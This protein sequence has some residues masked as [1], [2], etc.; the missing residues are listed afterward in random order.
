M[1][2]KGRS[3]LCCSNSVPQRGCET[4]ADGLRFSGLPKPSECPR[5]G[6]PPGVKHA[7]EAGRC[8]DDAETARPYDPKWGGS[9]RAIARPVTTTGS[10]C[11]RSGGNWGSFGTLVPVLH[12][13]SP[14]ACVAL[15]TPC[16]R[17]HHAALGAVRHR[18]DHDRPLASGGGAPVSPDPSPANGQIAWHR[19]CGGQR[20]CAPE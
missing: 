17:Y 1:S 10:Q 9:A 6:D 15:T 11:V 16:N 20:R 18:N 2:T 4:V 13:V 8:G 5:L 12:G 19:E 7:P 3:P 14:A